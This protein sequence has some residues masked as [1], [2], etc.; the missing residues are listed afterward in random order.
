MGSEMCIRDRC[1]DLAHFYADPKMVLAKL[2]TLRMV[3]VE[4]DLNTIAGWLDELEQ[5][6][7]IIRFNVGGKGYLE[8]VNCRKAL[9]SDVS[10]DVRFPTPDQADATNTAAAGQ[11]RD[12]DVTDAGRGRDDDGTLNQP[13]PTQTNPNQ[14]NT[15]DG[16]EP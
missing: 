5:R 12:D 7:L 14:P 8:I 1:D 3:N 2:F 4:V 6:D 9:R 10:R 13:K 11:A 16:T 15:R